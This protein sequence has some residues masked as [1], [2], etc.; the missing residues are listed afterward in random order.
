MLGV[1]FFMI[2][3]LKSSGAK[4]YDSYKGLIMAV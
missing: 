4:L 1:L 2:A 3:I